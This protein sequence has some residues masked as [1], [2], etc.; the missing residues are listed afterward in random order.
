[1]E[2]KQY[3]VQDGDVMNIRFNV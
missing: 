3:L 2:G 1:L